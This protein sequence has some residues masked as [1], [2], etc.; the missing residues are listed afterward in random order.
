M[1]S[2][3]SPFLPNP[4]TRA[5]SSGHNEISFEVILIRG[6]RYFDNISLIFKLNKRI[7]WKKK[8]M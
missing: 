5:Y 8:W 1:R 6:H 4:S 7:R 2:S 3:I